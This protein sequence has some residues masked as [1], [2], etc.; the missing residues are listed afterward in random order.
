M[1]VRM[2]TVLVFVLA[3]S[4]LAADVTVGCGNDEYVYGI[5]QAKYTGNGDAGSS[6]LEIAST[7]YTVPEGFFQTVQVGDW[8]RFNGKQWTIV[9]HAQS[10]FDNGSQNGNAT[11]NVPPLPPIQPTPAP[12]H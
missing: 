5:V 6:V 11:P 7:T 2:M 3:L 1:P 12:A 8:V 10:T 4:A 9:K